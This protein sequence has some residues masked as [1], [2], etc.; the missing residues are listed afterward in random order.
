M[1]PEEVR[2]VVE[3][4]VAEHG[5]GWVKRGAG[6][7]LLLELAP[8][9]HGEPFCDMSIGVGESRRV[10]PKMSGYCD[11]GI[12]RAVALWPE[13]QRLCAMLREALK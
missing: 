11:T 2:A 6:H 12:A 1:T 5:G 9:P 8:P 13:M 10:Y 3:R 7:G 4:V